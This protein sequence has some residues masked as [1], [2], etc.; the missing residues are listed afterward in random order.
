MI[1]NRITHFLIVFTLFLIFIPPP[2]SP[3]PTPIVITNEELVTVDESS[4]VVTWV[5]NLPSD[6]II[7]WGLTSDLGEENAVN[8]SVTHHLGR[9]K[10]LN[11]GTEYYYRIGSGERW[12]EVLSFTTLTE[13]GGELLIKFAVVADTH[14]DLDG[15]T[16]PNGLMYED[17][18]RLVGS[19]VDELNTI[20]DL[21]MVIA[22]GDMTNKGTEPDFQGFATSMDKLNAEWY[23]VLGNHDK[24]FEEWDQYYRNQMGRTESYYSFDK[25]I[26]HVIIMDSSV[27]GQVQG[28]IDDE[29]FTWLEN[30]LDSNNEKPI[31]IY[32]HHLTDRT[33]AMGLTEPAKTRLDN[34][35]SNRT[36]VLSVNAGHIH[37][38]INTASSGNHIITATAAVVSYPIGYSIVKLYTK[39]YLQSFHKIESELETSEA[40]RLRMKTSSVSSADEDA[41]GDLE[42]RSFVVGI[43]QAPQNRPPSV[44]GIT[45]EPKLILPGG[46]STITLT[47]SD[48]DGDELTYL[49][50]SSGGTISGSGSVVSFQAPQETGT[51]TIMGWVYDGEFYSAK[52]S[53]I[54][55]VLDDV[56][57]EVNTAPVIEDVIISSDSVNP[58]EIVK[59]EVKARDP[60]GDFLTYHYE[61]TDGDISGSGK[62]VEWHAPEYAG[63]VTITIRVSDGERDSVKKTLTLT[64]TEITSKNQEDSSLPGFEAVTLIISICIIMSIMGYYRTRK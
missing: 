9:I 5:T 21:D 55:D 57:P 39:G 19:M 4:A 26:Y 44:H 41:L 37:A 63:E 40:S 23:P 51:F 22:N 56:I 28:D 60:D 32:M 11:Q 35:L 8:E 59:I 16:T 62:K 33:D 30:E 45:S 3:A 48:P 24:T 17:S 12:G 50:E 13:P 1:I 46:F 53:V 27:T 15:Q 6:T 10:G 2:S 20:S 47:A 43:P 29:Q 54:I 31:L 14:Y 7:Q 18:V 42:D 25:E 34:I 52:T 36:N 58:N 64:V 49:Y 61:A 38:N